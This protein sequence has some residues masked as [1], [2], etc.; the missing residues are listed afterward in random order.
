MNYS[1]KEL[2]VNELL[3]LLWK[4]RLIILLLMLA[5]GALCFA[6]AYF[7]VPVYRSTGVLYVSNMQIE[8]EEQTTSVKSSNI[9][10]SRMLITTY[11]EILKT[12]DFLTE[13]SKDLNGKYT[14][15][16]LRSILSFDSVNETEL[17]SVKATSTDPEDSRAIVQSVLDNAPET[18]MRIFE[19]G[20]VKTVD[21]PK[22][23]PSP[24][25]LALS[26][27]ILFGLICGA[28]A[29]CLIVFLIHFF[30]KRIHKASDL[31]A[32]YG[33]SVLGEIRR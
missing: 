25:N 27:R 10:A 23:N 2:S 31:T 9:Q 3:E 17:L 11:I 19:S 21:K 20:S 22:V 7:S 8:E 32:R 26:R 16:Q 12:D 18:L 29:G 30:D 6:S 14:S 24:I 15:A 4:Y 33:L 1:S 13:V 5:G 28:L